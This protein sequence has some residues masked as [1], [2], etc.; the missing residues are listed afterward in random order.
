MYY[1]NAKGGF[2]TIE[3]ISWDDT[4]KT[5]KFDKFTIKSWTERILLSVLEHNNFA[6]YF[7]DLANS[8]EIF[9]AN[10][11]QVEL[12]TPFSK[13]YGNNVQ[14]SLTIKYDQNIIN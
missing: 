13:F 12:L 6:A 4:T 11:Q 10:G 1:L 3:C 8:I 14:L 5:E 7:K 2:Q 9:D